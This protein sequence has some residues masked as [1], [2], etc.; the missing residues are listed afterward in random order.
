M[1]LLVRTVA[2]V[3]AVWVLVVLILAFLTNL[4]EPCREEKLLDSDRCSVGARVEVVGDDYICRC[5]VEV[6][7]E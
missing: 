6:P 3:G 5:P 4:Q 7:G 1:A 2:L